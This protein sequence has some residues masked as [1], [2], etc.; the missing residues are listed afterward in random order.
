MQLTVVESLEEVPA[1]HWDA[2]QGASSYSSGRSFSTGHPFI[3]HAFLR[4]L[5]TSH[6]V[7]LGPARKHSGWHP[8]HLLLHN[9][10]DKLIGACPCYLKEH[11][12]GEYIFD[13]AW[14]NAVE[15]TGQRYY[16]KLVVGIPFT[17]ATG[18]RLLVHPDEDPAETQH[19]L[20]EGL[21]ALAEQVG[22]GSIHI[23]F[24]L[25]D[26]LSIFEK[27]GF[28]RRATH[29][30]HW[31]N[32]RPHYESF[33]AFLGCLR[34]QNRKQIRKERRQAVES[35]FNLKIELVRQGALN[36]ADF[37]RLF[38]LYSSTCGRKWGEAYLTK[39]FF[40][41]LADEGGK[42][43]LFGLAKSE[44]GEIVAMALSFTQ[45]DQVY[46]RYWGTSIDQEQLHFE[47][48]YYQLLDYAVKNNCVLVEAGAQGEHKVKRGFLPVVT[49]SAHYFVTPQLHQAI[50]N[51]V[52]VE[53][54]E[55]ER[56]IISGETRGPF[57]DGCVPPHEFRAG[58]E[59]RCD[60]S[61]DDKP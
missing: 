39:S 32:Q 38:E 51:A 5:E 24:C 35:D 43:A 8:L 3:R 20:A 50:G 23:L 28:F 59:V 45:Q 44:E 56:Q 52:K 53:C 48:C 31:R 57:K 55:V 30:F 15:R 36:Q 47:L 27:A 29:Q 61:P 1:E 9:D 42:D 40:D 54:D 17:P 11:S 26:E 21:R 14:A 7:G 25:D 18:P 10:D 4:L 58:Q 16:P 13:W 60:T 12:Y 49:H 33:D 19:L 41:G 37:T 2:L 22:A 34:S 46:G 6:S